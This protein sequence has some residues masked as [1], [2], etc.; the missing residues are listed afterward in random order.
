MGLHKAG[1]PFPPKPEK[2]FLKSFFSSDLNLDVL[3]AT[4][5]PSPLPSLNSKLSSSKTELPDQRDTPS[6]AGGPRHR[7]EADSRAVDE[8]REREKAE[9]LAGGVRAT[10]PSR[11]T[12]ELTVGQKTVEQTKSTKQNLEVNLKNDMAIEFISLMF[13]SIL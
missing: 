13:I 6:R 7:S 11:A 12:D 4:A 10:T 1:I 8:K 9:L 2:G 5:A 3:F